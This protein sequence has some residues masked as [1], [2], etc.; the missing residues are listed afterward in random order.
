MLS[1]GSAKTKAAKFP[2]RESTFGN[3]TA[4]RACAEELCDFRDGHRIRCCCLGAVEAMPFRTPEVL[5]RGA[6]E[7]DDNRC[8][9]GDASREP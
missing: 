1:R 3:R 5:R 6:S 7:L 8:T 9:T 4:F 2:V